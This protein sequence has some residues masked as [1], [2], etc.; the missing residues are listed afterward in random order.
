[1]RTLILSPR[2]DV[3]F[4][5]GPVP[6]QRSPIPEIRTHWANFVS[7]IADLT[8]KQGHDVEILELPLWQF[9]PEMVIGKNPD[10]VYVP[11]KEKHSFELPSH[12]EVLYY[13]QSVFPW[14]FYIDKQGYAG[15][16]S[17]YTRMDELISI[18]NP[19]GWMFDNLRH[20]AL[21][22]VSKFKQPQRGSFDSSV[23]GNYLFFACQLPHDHTIKY[24][25]DVSVEKALETTCEMANKLG[26]NLVVKGHPVNP[27]SMEGLKSI[28]AKYRNTIWVDDISIHDLIPN[29]RAVVVVN[30]GV[31]M[32]SLLYLK[33]VITFGRAEY[34]SL[35]FKASSDGFNMMINSDPIIDKI[36]V[37]KFF[38]IWS[39]LTFDTYV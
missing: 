31:G 2:L 8:N 18:G 28:C 5:E 3:T 23:F 14:I 22:G 25:S 17:Y 19:N 26:L 27:G 1:M 34:D 24:H 20:L 21:L 12:I 11:H 36:R 32:E 6:I 39:Q 35:T 37:R 7:R 4:K 9:T 33:P 13:M 30:S 15:G 10:L 38:D 16:A 29:A